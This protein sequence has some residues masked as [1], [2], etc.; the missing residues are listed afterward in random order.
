M[1]YISFPFWVMKYKEGAAEKNGVVLLCVKMS[2]EFVFISWSI[3]MGL[4]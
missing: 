1:N 3:F 2:R 4:T